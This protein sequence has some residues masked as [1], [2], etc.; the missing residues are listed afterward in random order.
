MSCGRRDNTVQ[1]SSPYKCGQKSIC[2]AFNVVIA[3]FSW[4]FWVSFL[5]V[6]SCGL[7]L[8]VELLG[9]SPY[10]LGQVLELPSPCS[11]KSSSSNHLPLVPYHET[12]KLGHPLII[13][14][15][16]ASSTSLDI[17]QGL[18]SDF[19]ALIPT[20]APQNSKFSLSFK[21]E[22]WDFDL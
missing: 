11:R 8:S 18:I 1:R 7:C 3:A 6:Y 21:E 12:F 2:H 19:W 9:G 10:L 17:A 13:C 22:K 4:I 14:S 15:S 16:T 20:I 5:F